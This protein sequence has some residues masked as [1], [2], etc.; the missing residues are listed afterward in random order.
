MTAVV[1]VRVHN[2]SEN[3]YRP[4]LLKVQGEDSAT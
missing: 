4:I 1:F 3:S 2:E